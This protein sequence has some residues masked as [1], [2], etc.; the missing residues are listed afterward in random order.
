MTSRVRFIERVTL[1]GYKTCYHKVCYI[2]FLNSFIGL[3]HLFQNMLLCVLANKSVQ[4]LC[5]KHNR[6][7]TDQ[8]HSSNPDEFYNC[9]VSAPAPVS[10]S[11]KTQS[12]T[13]CFWEGWKQLLFLP[14]TD[15]MNGCPGADTCRGRPLL[16]D[17][18]GVTEAAYRLFHSWILH[19]G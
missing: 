17:E 13:Y 7:H 14:L 15:V 6:R 8:T 5:D 4:F 18:P 19:V 1:T 16:H 2:N 11:N 10:S 9:E 12:F 3:L